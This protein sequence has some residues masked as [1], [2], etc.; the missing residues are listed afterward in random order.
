M[1]TA[2]TMRGPR[3]AAMTAKPSISDAETS[4]A[5]GDA[6][7]E[8]VSVARDTTSATPEA[9][10][11]PTSA[12]A[13]LRT[14]SSNTPVASAV[15][16]HMSTTPRIP[17]YG[18]STSG[19]DGMTPMASTTPSDAM[20]SERSSRGSRSSLFP[21]RPAQAPC[22][23]PTRP[24]SPP[25]SARTVRLDARPASAGVPVTNESAPKSVATPAT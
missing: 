9:A 8:T 24:Y 17:V 20:A 2:S 13:S 23:S 14:R 7:S 16:R 1:A 25:A 18:A 4:A 3:T 21:S 15:G 5:R 19:M 10:R 6:K 11:K 12:L 22:T